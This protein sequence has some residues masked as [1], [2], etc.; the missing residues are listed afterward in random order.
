MSSIWHDELYQDSI[1][2]IVFSVAML[3]KLLID[4]YKEANFFLAL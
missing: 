3:V 2:S 4:Q 1:K